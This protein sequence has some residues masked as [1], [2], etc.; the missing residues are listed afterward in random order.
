MVLCT[1]PIL[2]MFSAQGQ[3]N[4][5]LT[6]SDSTKV[7][8][9]NAVEI[10]GQKVL[11]TG[12]TEISPELSASPA[13]VTLLGSDYVAK[14]PVLSYGDLVRP[15]A[16]V[17]VAN[18]QNGG[19]GYGIEMRGYVTT[20]HAK[21]I[22]FNIDGVPQNQ[23]SSIQ[24]N[25]YVDLNMLI[26]ESIRK[27][28]VVRG[29]NSP[30]YGDHD[31]GGSI[32]FETENKLPSSVQVT[33]GTY[34]YL[35]GL[36][37]L[38]FGKN[39]ASGYIMLEGKR[40]DGYR[41]N[42][43]QK[44]LNGFAKYAFP[45]FNGV[46]SLRAQAFTADYNAPGYISRADID[47]GKISRNS[48]I[49]NTDHSNTRQQNVVLNYKGAD[50]SSYF[51]ATLFAQHHDFIRVRTGVIGGSQREERDNRTWYGGDFHHT[52]VTALGDMPFLYTIGI[53]LRSDDIA[54]TRFKTVQ[55]EIVNQN[56]DKQIQTN[57]PSVYL[58][59]QLKL[60]NRLKLTLG[61]RYD[62]LFYNLQTG[63]SDTDTANL[64]ISPSTSVFSPKVGVAYELTHGVSVF[65]N[66][67]Q[68]FKAPSAND[69]LPFNQT[70]T[71]SKVTSYEIGISGDNDNGRLHGLISAYFTKQT[72]EVATDPLGNLTNYGDTRRN[73]IEAEGRVALDNAG[74]LALFGNISFVDTK[75]LNGDAG[76]IYVI[77]TPQY[78]GLLGLDYNF[79]T[80]ASSENYVVASVYDQLIGIKNLKTDGSITSPAF[81][82]LGAKLTYKRSSF[83]NFSFFI[84]GTYYPGTASLDE[85]SFLSR[86]I[87]VTSPQAQAT[88]DAGFKFAF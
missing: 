38:G 82:R 67:S 57:T 66:A 46:A 15:L 86:G 87:I 3:D 24:A 41:E 9:L 61:A 21:D 18:F 6:K 80:T 84:E 53:G 26:P 65:A 70:L 10:T 2:M 78:T 4:N 20:E 59:T 51:A 48:Y 88:F 64:K 11:L 34:G 13:S 56:Q 44:G 17:A 76:S 33:G 32:V 55:G 47:N 62:Q 1:F 73:G 68:G 35:R 27:I 63:V 25:G 39:D 85:V 30:F 54:N 8:N 7:L 16:G 58:Q 40:S 14:Q 12:K 28:E 23:G 81:Q 31:L 52:T 79:G 42:T 19:V 71:I 49:N 22:Y 60:T 75:V 50:T 43:Q 77:N 29:P 72:G 37:V 36:G 83:S 69:D 74:G 5:K 45:L